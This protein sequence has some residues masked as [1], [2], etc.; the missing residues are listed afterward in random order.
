MGQFHLE[1]GFLSTSS[2]E[3]GGFAGSEEFDDVQ[4]GACNITMRYKVAAGTHDG[5]LL[6]GSDLTYSEGQSEYLVRSGSLAY[7]SEVE[8][9]KDGKSAVLD[10]VL[11]PRQFYD[12][13]R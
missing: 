8:M 1:K 6:V 2:V 11:I 9:S 5:I 3:E 4:R 7:V 13:E 12:P 10:C